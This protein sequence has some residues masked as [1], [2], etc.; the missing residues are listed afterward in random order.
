VITDRPVPA[1]YDLMVIVMEQR[2][3]RLH[4]MWRLARS[5]AP[6]DIAV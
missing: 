4:F 2:L 1:L 6:G 3:R 5:S